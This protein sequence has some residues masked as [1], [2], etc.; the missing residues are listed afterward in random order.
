MGQTEPGYPL[1]G[2]PAHYRVPMTTSAQPVDGGGQTGIGRLLEAEREWQR[3]LEFARAEAARV[4]AAAIAASDAELA[5]FE[6]ALPQ[7]IASRRRELDEETRRA[8]GDL[9]AQLQRQI[10]SYVR[11]DNA[12]V[13]AMAQ[14]IVERA[15]WLT[16]PVDGIA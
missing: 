11:P 8:A 12:F 7:I 16:G 5:A 9:L 1:G 14:R 15:P 10:D 3:Q 6:S 4:T 13:A 2:T